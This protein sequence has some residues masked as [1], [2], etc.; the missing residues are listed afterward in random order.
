M[1]PKGRWR[2]NVTRTKT[3]N[4]IRLMLDLE[5]ELVPDLRAAVE[6]ACGMGYFI[7]PPVLKLLRQ[8]KGALKDG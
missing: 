2:L 1:R 3:D 4:G 6:Q 8:L 5:A 7:T